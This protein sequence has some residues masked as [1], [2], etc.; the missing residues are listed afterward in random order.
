MPQSK[1]LIVDDNNA[2]AELLRA[3]L[4]GIDCE[5]AVAADGDETLAE[6]AGFRPDLILVDIALPK[7]SGFEVCKKLKRNLN[8]RQIVILLVTDLDEAGDIERAVESGC[9]D[10]LSKPVNKVELVNR[11]ENLLR[12]RGS[13]RRGST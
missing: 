10:F 7:L 8:T 11:V 4:G 9:N 6:V 5:I 2:S 13:G 3:Y 12:L 1:I